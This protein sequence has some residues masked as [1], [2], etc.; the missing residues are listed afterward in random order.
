MGLTYNYDMCSATRNVMR[1]STSSFTTALTW[2]QVLVERLGI[3]DTGYGV[4]S[5]VYAYP[6]VILPLFGGLL[7]DLVGVRA[8]NRF[9]VHMGSR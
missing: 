4:I 9:R 7:I 3:S 5:G 1:L 8:P 6:N 2:A